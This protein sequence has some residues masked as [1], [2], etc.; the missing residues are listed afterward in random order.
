MLNS[1]YHFKLIHFKVIGNQRGHATTNLIVLNYAEMLF[2]IL[3]IWIIGQIYEIYI[4][5][6]IIIIKIHKIKSFFNRNKYVKSTFTHVAKVKR[7]NKE[8]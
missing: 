7:E 8:Q 1:C 5:S 3:Y 6:S 4:Y 2:Y